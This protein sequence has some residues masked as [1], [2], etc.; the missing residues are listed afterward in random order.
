M[1][2]PDLALDNLQWLIC[3]KSK[4][5]CTKM[6]TRYLH[7]SGFQ[8]YCLRKI[9][10]LKAKHLKKK[11]AYARSHLEHWN[12]DGRMRPDKN[13]LVTGTPGLKGRNKNEAPKIKITQLL[14]TLSRVLCFGYI[15]VSE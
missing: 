2:K 13:F 8:D 14:S 5:K 6:N 11:S 15:S 12:S 7:Q 9:P 4:P 1:Y 10:L 3:N